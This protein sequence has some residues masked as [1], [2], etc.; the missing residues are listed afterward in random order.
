[1]FDRKCMRTKRMKYSQNE[2]AA[3]IMRLREKRM[4]K[5]RKEMEK[6]AR[7]TYKDQRGKR[8][9]VEQNSARD[10]E[11]SKWNIKSRNRMTIKQEQSKAVF[12]LLAFVGLHESNVKMNKR[13]E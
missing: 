12:Y 5:K 11:S 2:K 7:C 4:K 10:T 13:F 1:M 9:S 3:K 6:I 8:T